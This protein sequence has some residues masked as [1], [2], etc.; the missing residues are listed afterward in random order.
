[1]NCTRCTGTARLVVDD[2]P[3]VCRMCIYL[4]GSIA[5]DPARAAERILVALATRHGDVVELLGQPLRWH[6]TAPWPVAA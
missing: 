3:V 1:M 2:G 4:L 6:W 5:G